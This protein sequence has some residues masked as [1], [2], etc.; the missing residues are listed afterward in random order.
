MFE[1]YELKHKYKNVAAELKKHP[2]DAGYAGA[3]VS[4]DLESPK[5]Q[6]GNMKSRAAT[7]QVII[8]VMNQTGGN[9]SVQG[10]QA[11]AQ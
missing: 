10:S 1:N 5:D 8:T 9:A 2:N 3:T 4:R 7:S 6:L 11:A